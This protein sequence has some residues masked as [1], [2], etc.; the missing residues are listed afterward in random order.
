M[1]TAIAIDDEPV[2]LDVIKS[3]AIQ[4]PFLNLQ[5][6]FLSAT[7]ALNHIKINPV[8]LVFL[9]ISM[10]GLSGL[11]FAEIVKHK[12]Q[13]VFTTAHPE[14]ALKGFEL[15]A[16]DYLLKPFNF[17][18]FL[19]ACELAD[20]RA[21]RYPNDTNPQT[22]LV[23]DG[24]NWVPVKLADLLYIRGEDNYVSLFLKDK[25]ILTRM[26]LT[27]LQQKLPTNEF[28]RVHKSYIISL[29][30]IEKIEKHQ[31]SIAEAKI[32]LSMLSSDSILLMLS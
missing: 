13:L 11:G 14:H 5:A 15:A 8:G 10:P 31:V 9:D 18:R 1:I 32:P 19:Q 2:A 27:E 16:T 29:S 6:T 17:S 28:L 4:V 23:K 30:K 22:L 26:T 12:T 7:Q 20:V 24:H 21:S 25:R 3:H